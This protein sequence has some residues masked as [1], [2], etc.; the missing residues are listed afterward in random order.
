MNIRRRRNRKIPPL[1]MAAMPDLIFTV[2][3]F[4]M[5][6]TN[7]RTE[8][9]R[10][11]LE[12]PEGKELTKA[13][14]KRA[15]VNLYI[16]TDEKGNTRIQIKDRIVSPEMVGRY[17]QDIYNKMS[18]EDRELFVVNIKADKNTPMGII[19]DVKQELR[20]AGALKIRYN[21]TEAA[22]GIRQ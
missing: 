3:F 6:V 4:F 13:T 14:H 1:N 8:T 20:K 9:Q 10:L 11:T 5:I 15:I 21:A 22:N 2:L 7:M 19:S 12:V 18:S 16:G 17:I